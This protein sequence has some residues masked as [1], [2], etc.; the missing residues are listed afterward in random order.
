MK[1]IEDKG[2]N[3]QPKPKRKAKTPPTLEMLNERLDKL[4]VERTYAFEEYK[5]AQ[6]NL[7][8]L[9]K[10][11]DLLETQIANMKY[12]EVQP[13]DVDWKDLL[14]ANMGQG[15]YDLMHKKWHEMWP[16]G[17]LGPNEYNPETGQYILSFHL[18]KPKCTD[19]Y[20]VAM[21]KVLTFMIPFL[22]PMEGKL[23]FGIT[24]P[25]L[26]EFTSYDIVYD[27]TSNIWSLLEGRRSNKKES[28]GTNHTLTFLKYLAQRHAFNYSG[29]S[30]DD[31]D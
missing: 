21:E 30:E 28:F 22:I 6:D 1:Q 23:K 19:E 4:K 12:K 15:R 5:R 10:N 20:L 8:D 31:E 26:S 18:D 3:E 27:P 29:N 9:G 14:M 13:L 24:E 2:P 11:I 25:G 7:Q 16:H 17:G